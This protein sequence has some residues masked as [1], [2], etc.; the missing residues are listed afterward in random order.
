MSITLRP[1]KT[2]ALRHCLRFRVI[3]PDGP[4][5]FVEELLTDGDGRI[6][7]LVVGTRR[8][9]LVL[10]SDVIRI[11]QAGQFVIARRVRELVVSRP[12][13]LAFD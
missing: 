5:G 2:H 8:P 6:A 3:G 10:A 12:P 13:A 9:K 1:G 4:D 11:D 7:G